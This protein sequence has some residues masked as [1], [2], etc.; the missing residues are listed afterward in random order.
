[1]IP[2]LTT[3][4]VIKARSI[5]VVQDLDEP[6]GFQGKHIPLTDLTAGGNYIFSNEYFDDNVSVG[7]VL[8]NAGAS[9]KITSSGNVVYGLLDSYTGDVV[10]FTKV[11]AK[12]GGGS[13]TNAD[14]DGVIIRKKGAFF[15][16]RNYYDAVNV[17]WF[18]VVAG[19]ADNTIALQAAFNSGNYN[20]H[21]PFDVIITGLTITNKSN[22]TITCDGVIKKK[23]AAVG[24]LITIVNS[25]NLKFFN[26]KTDGNRSNVP[27]GNLL[28][29]QANIVL[30]AGQSNITFTGGSLTNSVFSGVVFNGQLENIIFDGV[31]L[32][33]I[34][35]HVF[36]VSGGANKNCKFRNLVIE[37][38]A[39]SNDALMVGHDC[40]V[41]NI[42]GLSY[43]QNTGFLFENIKASFNT[44]PRGV[45]TTAFTLNYAK[46]FTIRNVKLTGDG[47]SGGMILFSEGTSA[48]A[49]ENVFIDNISTENKTLIY[50]ALG[51]NPIFK[52]IVLKNSS[53]GNGSGL[54]FSYPTIFSLIDNCTF[55]NVRLQDYDMSSFVLGDLHSTT[56]SNSKFINQ[57]ALYS[58]LLD[59]L[60]KPIIFSNTKFSSSNA[61][62][63]YIVIA[64]NSAKLV[65]FL[66]CDMSVPNWTNSIAYTSEGGEGLK[67]D[68]G[69]W[70]GLIRSYT[71]TTMPKLLH[72]ANIKTLSGFSYNDDTTFPIRYIVNWN[73]VIN[74]NDISISSDSVQTVVPINNKYDFPSNRNWAVVLNESEYGDFHIKQSN[75][76]RGGGSSGT[77]RLSI[78]L[79]GVVKAG[80]LDI[81]GVVKAAAGTDPTHLITKAQLD[82]KK[83]AAVAN[84]STADA[85][86]AATA[87]TLANANKAKINELLTAM[88]AGSSPLL[89]T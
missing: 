80:A 49:V 19:V 59:N 88:R 47:L 44:N 55:D 35:E 43:G 79:A 65:S 57:S 60:I 75:T 41:F 40:H 81:A 86:D 2:N 50:N 78:T 27:A 37:N 9:A 73:G 71:A 34:G 42:K 26:L 30:G 22:I 7:G 6:E 64:G 76:Q 33:S 12:P 32:S 31:Y 51:V 5:A 45:A 14:I 28:G 56:I 21:I 77:S 53:F 74:R 15:F 11:T 39:Q 10:S 61:G 72:I 89:T 84:I 85:T 23:D 62:D 29:E 67:I 1:M 8:V 24:H 20:F 87:I 63:Y 46:D 83:S 25:S 13:Y 48:S 54:Y 82:G 70:G 52:N 38:I 68:G 36:Y 66:N 16:K 18:G 58:H 4:A 17:A 3:K 69:E